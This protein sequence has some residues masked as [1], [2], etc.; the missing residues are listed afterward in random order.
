MLHLVG[1]TFHGPA[2]KKHDCHQKKRQH[3]EHTP[4]HHQGKAVAASCTG[5]QDVCPVS[6][7]AA[8]EDHFAPCTAI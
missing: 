2:G 6:T 3:H 8:F 1:H 5:T 4:H 7:V